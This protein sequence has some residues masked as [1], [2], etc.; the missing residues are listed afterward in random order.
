MSQFTQSFGLNL[1]DSLA[2]YPKVLAHLFQ[3][4]IFA[5]Q[6]AKTHFQHFALAFVQHT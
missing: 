6:Q 3:G 5:I 4:M 2:S 1:P